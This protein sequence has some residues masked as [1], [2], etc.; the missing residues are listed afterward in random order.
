MYIYNVYI[1]IYI[2]ITYHYDDDDDDTPLIMI[3][4][5]RSQLDKHSSIWRWDVTTLED[6]WTL[7]KT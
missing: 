6:T 3:T 5:W 2:F 4:T 7:S 1:Y